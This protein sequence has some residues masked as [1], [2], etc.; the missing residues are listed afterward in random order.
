M[1][2]AAL[3]G[4]QSVTAVE[5]NL[6]SMFA[7]F[8]RGRGCALVDE[9]EVLR[10][11]TPLPFVPYNAVLRFRAE[12]GV[13]AKVEAI[14][15]HHRRRGVPLLWVLHP[16]ARPDDLPD[17]LRDH[18]LAEAERVPGM[19][20]SLQDLPPLEPP[21]EGIDVARVDRAAV[22][23]FLDLLTWRYALPA[24]AAPVLRSIMELA[25]FGEPDAP[26]RG[27]VAR[28][29]GVV[30]SKAVLHLGAG[31]AG[32]YGVATRAEARG[33][34]L[35]RQLTLMALHDARAVGA[36]L[37]VLHATP[38]AVGLYAGLGFVTVTELA[39]WSD[40]GALHL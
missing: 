7:Q 25:R 19:V 37:A 9:P 40:P 1:G 33:L 8:G 36:D 26:T 30:L 20:R 29:D 31:V 21:P 3:A 4:P 5:A 10:F 17:R 13:D 15:D 2:V 22:E 12:S 27:Y 11:E 18:G 28:R 6:W 24:D 38:M 35:A 39:L 23:G 16:S 34:G 32:I 14:V